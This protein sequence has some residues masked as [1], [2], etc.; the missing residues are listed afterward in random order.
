MSCAGTA[1]AAGISIRDFGAVGDGKTLDTAAI[2]K[3]L[4]TVASDGG[5]EVLIP[6]GRYV[7]GSLVLKSH[8]TLHLEAGA[9]LQGSAN[10]DNYPIVQARWEGI[11]TNCHQALIS[12][13]HAED[14]AITGAGIIEGN[15]AVGRLRNPRGVPVIEL[16]ECENVRVEGVTLKSTR[17]WTLHP[18]Y[19]DDV[20]VSGVTFDTAG[21]NSDGIDPDSCRRVVIDDCTFST[22][23]DNIA[24]K[25]GKGQEGVRI[26]RPSE[27]ILITNCTFIKGYTSIAFGSELSGGIRRVHISHCTFRQ[28]RAALQL[29]SRSG[30]AG[31]LEDITADHLVVGSEPMLEIIGNYSFN[32]D[33][34]GVPG[35][36]GLTQFSRIRITDVSIHSK[37]LLH[38]D[39]PVGKPVNGVVIS[40]VTGTCETGSVIQNI[41]NVDLSDVHLDGIAGPPYF[42]NN[43]TGTGLAGAVPLP[44]PKAPTNTPS[45]RQPLTNEWFLLSGN[46]VAAGNPVGKDGFVRQFETP[47]LFVTRT[48][49]AK[50]NGTVL[51]LP[52]GAYKL[53]DIT[54]EG[55]RTAKAL[56]NF[57]YDV[58]MLEYHVNSGPNT[59]DLALTDAMTAWRLLKT[60][61]D[62]LGV[63]S[64][65]F[66][67]MGYS[68]GGHLA[69]RLE[70]KLGASASAQPDDLI[71]VYPAYLNEH[72]AGSAA[73]R[74]PPPPHPT[75]RLVVIMATNDRPAWVEGA[76]NYVVAWRKD[77]GYG[78]FQ[79][80]KNGG[81]GFGM[82]TNLTGDIAQWPA[83]LDYF[84]QNGPNPGAGPFNTF[85]PWFLRNNRDR[86][87]TF[88]RDAAAD[89]GAIVFFG[90]SITRKWD[91]AM[92]FPDL[93]AANRGISGD[94]TRGMLCRVKDTVLDLHP[95]AI[96]FMGGIND[97]T[98]QP[99][100]TPETIATNVRSILEQIHTATPDTPVLV[101]ETLP[102]KG[103][104]LETI[105][106]V[107]AVVD[108]V[109]A[110]FPN[111]HRVKTYA[112]FLKPDGT[113]NFSLFVDGTHPNAR[114]YAIWEKILVPE[115]D[116]YVQ[117]H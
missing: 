12:A 19:C 115:L 102:S 52:G 88:R 7:S 28:G 8:T 79:A 98:C 62:D 23:D 49:A 73:P 10:P 101:C 30:R 43:V 75:A 66:V 33:P 78:I 117:A 103:A 95:K 90:D 116:K 56:N 87:R 26:G 113:E 32:P 93:K 27:D 38:I 105:Q 51:L 48:A 50:P 22:G 15:P 83:V 21:A 13:D 65:R 68:A 40:H 108:K 6:A 86:L 107:N 57:G 4:N 20:R 80:F 44:K 85:L 61:P 104:P 53:L 35:V 1:F 2:Q 94:T 67:L 41:R 76:T 31:Y 72:A 97:L 29:K 60:H 55:S 42:T 84:L 47:A 106:A 110:D 11:E 25:S 81:H 99:Q 92:A 16:T 45:A 96:V 100:G 71:L 24:I 14:I 37:N 77:G 89:Q 82:K 34:Q 39:G 36:K 58:A 54:D 64:Q 91:I 18:T 114:G 70:E 69:A 3:A 109:I 111:A 9:V 5:G 46:P 59:R 74:V 112:A 63:H 17:M